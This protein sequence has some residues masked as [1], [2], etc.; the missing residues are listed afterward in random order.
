MTHLVPKTVHHISYLSRN[1][2]KVA[3]YSLCVM[4]LLSPVL[5]IPVILWSER[6]PRRAGIIL[7]HSRAPRLSL[8][9]SRAIHANHSQSRRSIC[10][11]SP[12]KCRCERLGM[13]RN[14]C[15]IWGRGS[16]DRII[17]ASGRVYWPCGRGRQSRM[18]V[19][20]WLFLKNHNITKK[21]SA[22][23]YFLSDFSNGQC[24]LLTTVQV[25]LP[26]FRERHRAEQWH[27]N[28]ARS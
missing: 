11:E 3:V 10:R 18:Y 4:I 22:V 26:N 9:A 23:G 27:V 6:S 2:C 12:E 19:S 21:K 20:L 15:W 17:S 5:C 13:S 14:F 28:N 25:W 7:A 16:A 1:T 24:C 8:S